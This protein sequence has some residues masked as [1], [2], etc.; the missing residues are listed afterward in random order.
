MSKKFTVVGLKSCTK[1]EVSDEIKR[2]KK[3]GWLVEHKT[4][5]TNG[6]LLPHNGVLH[7]KRYQ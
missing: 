6:D 1:S 3:E 4:T 2:F 7:L 5:Y